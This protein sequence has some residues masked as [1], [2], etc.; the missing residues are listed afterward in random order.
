[1]GWAVSAGETADM[2]PETLATRFDTWANH[3]R[4]VA[5]TVQYR[6]GFGAS[7]RQRTFRWYA[8]AD[9]RGARAVLTRLHNGVLLLQPLRVV[10]DAPCSEA[11]LQPWL[12]DIRSVHALPISTSEDEHSEPPGEALDLPAIQTA[13]PG[14]G[15]GL[16]VGLDIGGT[17]M[18]VCALQDG[19]L[20][21]TAQGPTW[22]EGEHGLASIVGRARA[23]VQEV[24]AGERPTSLGIGLASPMGVHGQVVSLSTVMRE[25]LGSAASLEAL[26]AQVAEGLVDG[27][28]AIFNDLANL[29]RLLSGR[30]GR[31]LLRLQVGTSFGGC[32]V[33]A[34]G[35]VSASELGRLVV[36]VAPTARPH[37]YLPLAGAMKSYLSNFGVARSLSGTRGR[38]VTPA[39]AGFAWRDLNRAGDPVGRELVAWL[40]TLL[41]GA[42]REA[43]AVLPGLEE[44]E[45]GGGMLQGIT[46]R[47]VQ[48]D[49]RQRLGELRQAPRFAISS[50]PGFDGAVAAARAPLL[51]APLRGVRRLTG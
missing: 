11:R 44:V 19:V 34:D 35:T 15:R 18:K 25:R 33:D 50:N 12:D 29:G 42:I 39:E 38:P 26:P 7:S 21:R 37:T 10:L 8:P 17:G 1:M 24:C 14:P 2:T 5:W 31:R 47:L 28:V 9:A 49:V 51:D 46:G 32:W 4:S 22:P 23:L 20:M 45:L 41:V 48:A 30:G 43:L 27:P 40:G 36:D 6:F 16:A 3:P 13:D